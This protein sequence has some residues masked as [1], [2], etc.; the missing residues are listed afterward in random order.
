MLS[1]AKFVEVRSRSEIELSGLL[2]AEV[3][4]M[5]ITLALLRVERDLHIVDCSAKPES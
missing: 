1:V 4:L 2:E 5:K 3:A